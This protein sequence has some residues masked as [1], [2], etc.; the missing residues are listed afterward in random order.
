MSSPG[1]WDG[2]RLDAGI[3]LALGLLVVAAYL[4]V[5]T[6][7]FIT[8]DDALYVTENPHVLGGLSLASIRWAFTNLEA[9]NWH[10]LTWLSHMADISLFGTQPGAHHLVNVALHLAN[11]ILCFYLLRAFTG[12]RWRSALV[13]ALFALHPCHV[14]SVAWIAERKDVLSTFFWLLTTWAY[15]GQVRRPSRLQY[16]LLLALF[17]LGLMAKSMLVTLPATLMLL[18][19]W[20]L[21]RVASWRDLGASAW[22]KAPLFAIAGALALTTFLAQAH[23][24][25]LNSLQ[26]L[27]L[28]ARLPNALLSAVRYLS[29]GFWPTQLAVFYPFPSKPAPAWALVGAAALLAGLTLVAV[30]QRLRRPWLLMGWAWYL[31]T[32]APVIGVIQVGGQAMADRYTYIP[33]LG[34][35]IIFAWASGQLVEGFEAPQWLTALV[36]TLVLGTLLFMTIRQVSYWRDTITLFRHT[37][38]VTRHNPMANMNIAY[39]LEAK[40]RYQEA[41]EAYAEAIRISPDYTRAKLCLGQTL[42]RL[43]RP[44]EA[45]GVYRAILSEHPNDYEAHCLQ[46][47]ALMSLGRDGEAMAEYRLIQ[48]AEP[49][50]LGEGARGRDLALAAHL[51][52]GIILLRRHKPRE[53]LSPLLGAI[54][55][56]PLSADPR[57]QTANHHAALAL[58]DLGH[59]REAAT[60]W[61]QSLALN[62]KQPD[63]W[64]DLGRCLVLTGE[65]QEAGHAFQQAL[66]LDP[67]HQSAQAALAGL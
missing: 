40:G 10:P 30:R 58:L 45:I 51:N 1:T 67:G 4:Q 8:Y 6:F 50:K 66:I 60:L 54:K 19:F 33:Y 41:M 34:P 24:G 7:N 53:A 56:C 46:G 28:K 29:N 35:F 63:A 36:A 32:L 39:A 57:S 26:G 5:R 49:P 25:A 3:A 20:P 15:L 37:S 9:A 13:A 44:Q 43:G 59:P 52:L 31:I 42:E 64:F 14:E 55:L 61:R 21:R 65:R 16:C 47:Q 27:P 62:P 12:S 22:Q 17:T 48:D 2:R 23:G 18:D 38:Q 11:S